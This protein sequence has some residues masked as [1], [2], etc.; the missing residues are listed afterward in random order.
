MSWWVI[1]E[2]VLVERVLVERVLVIA[3]PGSW[4]ATG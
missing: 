4:G 3:M 2:R 1:V